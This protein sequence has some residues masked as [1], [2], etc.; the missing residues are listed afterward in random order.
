MKI[1]NILKPLFLLLINALA[2]C[3]PV[4]SATLTKES[5]KA[6][7]IDGTATGRRGAYEFTIDPD[8]A[9]SGVFVLE[10]ITPKANN[11]L[12]IKG[13]YKLDE[14]IFDKTVE[15]T[16][17]ALPLS[18]TTTLRGL[19]ITYD[20]NK[21]LTAFI[22][23]LNAKPYYMPQLYN[24]QTTEWSEDQPSISIDFIGALQ[25]L[26]FLS[27]ANPAAHLTR[28]EKQ[29]RL[30]IKCVFDGMA[31]DKAVKILFHTFHHQPIPGNTLQ[32]CFHVT[33][34]GSIHPVAIQKY[35]IDTPEFIAWKALNGVIGAN[36]DI[37]SD[38]ID[39]DAIGIICPEQAPGQVIDWEQGRYIRFY[40]T[41]PLAPKEPKT[42][43]AASPY[44]FFLAQVHHQQ[45]R[46]S[47]QPSMAPAGAIKT[48]SFLK[49]T[50]IKIEG[51]DSYS[52]I[53]TFVDNYYYTLIFSK[54]INNYMT[55]RWQPIGKGT[56][57]DTDTVIL[58]AGTTTS[59]PLKMPYPVETGSSLTSWFEYVKPLN[60]F[61]V[62]KTLFS[63]CGYYA[64][65]YNFDHL[66]LT[67]DDHS[68]ALE[69]LHK[70][71][72]NTK[73][74]FSTVNL[75]TDDDRLDARLTD[76]LT[77]HHTARSIVVEDQT[78]KLTPALA[79]KILTFIQTKGVTDVTLNLGAS[80]LLEDD[81]LSGFKDLFYAP[82]A[83]TF[84][85][86]QRKV[87]TFGEISLGNY[88]TT[89]IKGKNF[90]DSLI[91]VDDLCFRQMDDTSKWPLTRR[92]VIDFLGRCRGLISLDLNKTYFTISQRKLL[93]QAIKEQSDSL[94]NFQ[95]HHAGTWNIYRPLVQYIESYEYMDF[96]A[97]LTQLSSLD[98]LE[99]DLPMINGGPALV[100]LGEE[101]L[102]KLSSI[103]VG[104]SIHLYDARPFCL[105]WLGHRSF[106]Y[107]LLTFNTRG[108]TADGT[109]KQILKDSA[110][111]I[112]LMPW[113]E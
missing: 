94:E 38:P 80:N 23:E 37:L 21:S 86:S 98:S 71:Y 100:T 107:S 11:I 58:T 110:P 62:N 42:I 17:T 59:F 36:A 29:T 90:F 108:L 69:V 45:I 13:Q 91:R 83:P 79:Q 105:F 97:A 53:G 30:F 24:W 8:A 60:R 73:V 7:V 109:I 92:A 40:D 46:Q 96:V 78:Q 50:N 39:N 101:A 67:D 12:A 113:T 51:Y 68:T 75:D 88:F 84:K 54:N 9:D 103:R 19:G 44:N 85:I 82:N 89:D 6:V 34:A 4:F 33:D 3:A 26:R 15:A 77:K 112:K 95:W 48:L 99:I 102:R 74:C 65:A 70:W 111:E 41:L 56:N 104:R 93:F 27:E 47:T 1:T 64:N 43:F 49:P 22:A 2:F 28:E 52:S 14:D 57:T 32:G 76:L 25:K 66:D 55:Q 31:D 16:P 10:T 87:W 81:V 20:P 35:R 72:T 106:T 61:A 18:E 63:I 5:I